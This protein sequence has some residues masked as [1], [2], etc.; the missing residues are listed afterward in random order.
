MKMLE[1]DVERAVG[2]NKTLKVL[3]MNQRGVL[4]EETGKNALR[5]G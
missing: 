5:E 2:G 4:G 1:N 3:L